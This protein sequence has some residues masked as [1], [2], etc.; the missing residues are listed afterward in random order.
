MKGPGELIRVIR[1]S[2]NLSINELA[3]KS[4]VSMA[5]ISRIETGESGYCDESLNKIA[6]ALGVPVGALFPNSAEEAI[7]KLARSQDT[8][9]KELLDRMT[10][11]LHLIAKSPRK[12]LI[13]ILDSLISWYEGKQDD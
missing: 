10:V 12:D 2:Q 11:L 5:Q 9:L 1:K 3:A 6:Q 7:E 8:T 4:G 13:P